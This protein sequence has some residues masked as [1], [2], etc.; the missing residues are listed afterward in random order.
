MA[1]PQAQPLD[2]NGREIEFA[3]WDS[4]NNQFVVEETVAGTA[5]TG[6]PFNYA[7]KK[8]AISSVNSGL[9]VNL[10]AIV[11]KAGGAS[12]GSVAS[13]AQAFTSAN[14]AGNSI[15]VVCAVGNNTAPTVADSLG[16]TYTQA[17]LVARSTTFETAIFFASN[18]LAGANTV[19]VT[20]AG[21]AASVA[22]EIYEVS[23]LI[24]QVT[25][26]PDQTATNNGSSGTASTSAINPLSPNE[27]A[28]AGVAVG[29][30]A[31]TI[32][33]ATGW[34]ND[35]G[36][37]NPTTPAGFYSFVSMSQFL[38]SLAAVTP[39]ATFT[40]EPWAIACATF[41]PVILGIEGTIN[42]ASPYPFGSVPLNATSGDVAAATAAATLSAS[43]GK[44]TYITGFT[45]TSTGSTGAAT[46]DIT[47]TDGTWTVTFVYVS[48]AGATTANTQLAIT[49]PYPLAASAANTTIVASCPTLG[50]GNLHACMNAYGFKL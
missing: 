50:T 46:V 30:A 33:P 10:P 32:T 39:Q 20:N 31:Q 28:F 29:T 24:A 14:K 1:L 25:A 48:V 19:T 2:A 35:S 34:S 27:L 12:T 23:G 38:G 17:A 18:I 37:L 42:I 7:A 3:G 26:Q 36:Q 41:R 13:L 4:T 22:V 45:F 40:T 9:P 43:A 15:V 6:Q 11:Q 5:A 16:N 21:S 49:F 8:V 47:V 44:T